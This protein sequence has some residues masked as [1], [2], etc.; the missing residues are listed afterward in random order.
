MGVLVFRNGPVFTSDAAG[1]MARAVAVED[2]VIAAVGGDEEVAPWLARADDVVDLTGR[3]LLP[4]FVDAHVH[5]VL[6]GIERNRCDLSGV[7]DLAAYQR[8]IAG[9]AAEHPRAEWILGGGWD[10]SAFPRG[11]PH[12]D[13]LDAVAGGRPVYLPNRDHHSAWVSTEALR[14][15]G[16]TR[17]TPDPP[18]GRIERD[19]AGEPT[20]ALH[21][22]AMRLVERHVPEATQADHDAGLRTAIAYLNSVGVVGWQDAAVPAR[23]DQPGAHAAYLRAAGEGWLH[24]RVSSALWWERGTTA[25]GVDDEVGRLAAVRD[26]TNALGSDRYAIHSVKVMQDGVPETYTAAMLEPYLDEHGCPSDNCGIS[27]LEKELLELVV[28]RLDATGFQLHFHAIGD[29]AVRDVLDALE[30]ARAANGTADRRHHLAHVQ[31]VNP[32]EVGRFRRAGAAAN[33][34]ALWARHEPQMDDLTIPF[35]GPER[36]GHQYVFGS[37]FRAGATIVM[38]SDWPVSTANPMA[39][40]HV[41]VNRFPPG[42]P[43]QRRRPLG[44]AQELALATALRA[45]TAGSAYINRREHLTGTIRPG[46]AA[47]L[48]VLEQDPFAVPA[49]EIGDIQVDHTFVAGQEVYR[50]T[51]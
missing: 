46:A 10:M 12:R 47:D 6:G 44:V 7:R 50:R 28:R 32:A 3:M 34:Q 26:E 37:L 33:I 4:G 35:L 22:G 49:P 24:G 8:I 51:P 19:E 41:A 25:D 9:Y 45:Y 30:A 48:V 29:R 40:I 14:R 16:V 17:D 38:G 5:P 27:F 21:D 31:V 18:D 2:G 43:P 36:A 20:G 23:A 15:A 39:A 42:T 1:S 11:L 13:M